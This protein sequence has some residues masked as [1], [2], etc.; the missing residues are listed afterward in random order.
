MGNLLTKTEGQ[1]IHLEE[2]KWT[3]IDEYDARMQVE[4]GFCDK[5]VSGDK[6]VKGAQE[7]YFTHDERVYANRFFQRMNGACL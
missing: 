5:I 1:V 6:C 7:C 4:R 2:K 3:D